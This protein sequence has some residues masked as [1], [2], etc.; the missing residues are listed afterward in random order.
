MIRR[1][2]GVLITLWIFLSTTA[3]QAQV[4]LQSSGFVQNPNFLFVEDAKLKK[5]L[6]QPDTFQ[7][8]PIFGTQ[9]NYTNAPLVL[10][11]A[12]FTAKTPVVNN[13]HSL[14][15]G[16]GILIS[17]KLLIGLDFFVGVADF[18]A[19]SASWGFGDT[20]LMAKYQL[21]DG[22]LGFDLTI[23]PEV[24]LP[25][26][27]GV[28]Y[29]T[30]GS[31]APGVRGALE[32]DFRYLHLVANLGFE[33]FYNA[34]YL[35]I[36]S[37][38]RIPMALGGY[39]PLGSRWGIDAEMQTTV[40]FPSGI[41][42]RKGVDQFY[43]GGK[44]AILRSTLVSLGAT[45]GNFQPDRSAS[46]GLMAGIKLLPFM[47]EPQTKEGCQEKPFLNRFVA[48]PLLPEEA[49]KAAILPYKST[50]RHEIPTLQLGQMTA[51]AKGGVPYVYA[52]QT[53]FAID[54]AGLPA[55]SAIVGV[56]T[57]ALRMNLRKVSKSQYLDTEIICFVEER[58]CSGEL[59]RDKDWMDNLNQQFLGG[60]ETPNDFFIRQFLDREVGSTERGKIFAAEVTLPLHKLLENSTIPDPIDLIYRKDGKKTRLDKRTLYLVVG[61]DTYVS[62]DAFLEVGMRE[63]TC[64]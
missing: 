20:R 58:I 30:N 42:I 24:Y 63:N 34:S 40:I 56:D 64:L 39:V 2:A 5:L 32:Y 44:F 7:V 19:M 6:D 13:L 25:T 17:P 9:Y 52:S 15:L 61:D 60:K 26:G 51:L 23:I 4:N 57:L 22:L 50:S 3:S 10:W 48:R 35:G 33:Y 1:G 28:T 36:D 37:R 8:S 46:F 16:S 47:K 54:I 18:P 27:F 43:L 59:Y 49:D 55:R 29:F 11:D 14:L 53:V 31:F 62:S 45:V 41:G 12:S 38:I 21:L